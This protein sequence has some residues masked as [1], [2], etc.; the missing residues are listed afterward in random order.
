MGSQ[1]PYK[2]YVLVAGIVFF[3]V[4]F[5]IIVLGFGQKASGSSVSYMY[6]YIKQEYPDIPGQRAV[7][8][9]DQVKRSSNRFDV[10]VPVILA[11]MDQESNF[12]NVRSNVDIKPCSAGY[13][14]VTRITASKLAGQSLTCR[15]LIVNWRQNIRL[16]VKYIKE[17]WDVTGHLAGAIGRYNGIHN[18]DYVHDVLNKRQQILELKRR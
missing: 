10:P 5:G 16:G 11:V 18:L 15:D 13:M 9:I 1:L 3:L 7:G 14:Q 6:E 17:M 12:R 2:T 8:I 4:V